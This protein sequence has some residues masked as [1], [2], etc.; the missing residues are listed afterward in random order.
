MSV[1]DALLVQAACAE[2]QSAPVQVLGSAEGVTEWLAAADRVL[3]EGE[4]DQVLD[5][6]DALLDLNVAVDEA[7]LLVQA[8]TDPRGEID[9]R[10]ERRDVSRVLRSLDGAA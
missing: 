5:E 10:R 4:L 2:W 3:V 8:G 9:R 6:Y 7:L 1:E